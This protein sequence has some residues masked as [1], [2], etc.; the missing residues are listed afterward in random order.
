VADTV[1]VGGWFR[2]SFLEIDLPP[3]RDPLPL[4][5]LGAAFEDLRRNMA[6]LAETARRASA[7][8]VKAWSGVI[9]EAIAYQAFIND[10]GDPDIIRAIEEYHGIDEQEVREAARGWRHE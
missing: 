7:V 10:G 5:L 3:K 4:A 8:F 6:E 2:G 9:D 1:R